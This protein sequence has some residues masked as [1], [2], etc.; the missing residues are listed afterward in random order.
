MVES[1]YAPD[2]NDPSRPLFEQLVREFPPPYEI[3][4]RS[5]DLGTRLSA[6]VK[7]P[8]TQVAVSIKLRSS[9]G[10]RRQTLSSSEL[11]RVRE[12][13]ASGSTTDLHI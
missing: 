4:R 3:W 12:H 9:T 8:A 2:S 1:L 13:F 7:L 11:D 6:A 10:Q 5:E